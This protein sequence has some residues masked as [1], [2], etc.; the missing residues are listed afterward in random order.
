MTTVYFVRHAEPDYSIHN[1]I[2]RP[3]T[4]RGKEDSQ[5]V[6]YF[7]RDKHIDIVLSSPYTRA[8]DTVKDFADSYG[9]SILVVDD[10]RERK[11]DNVWIEDFNQFAELQWKDFEY[12]LSDGECLREVQ[13]R[14]VDALMKVLSEHR[15][16]RIVIGSHGTALS[17]IINYF[18][19]TF[20][21]EDFQRIKHIMPWIVKLSFQ[22]DELIGMEELDVVR[23]V[24][25]K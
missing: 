3:L 24:K 9:H 15:D 10:F 8:I 2:K 19:P 13:S 22:E 1:D 11:V 6:T 12:K 23:E 4:Q 14:N 20:G 16:Q 18:I 25:I 17:T 7:L 21:F 5:V